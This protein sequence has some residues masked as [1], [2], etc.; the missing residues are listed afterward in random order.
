MPYL[1]RARLALAVEL[2]GCGPRL[3]KS[4]SHPV[5]GVPLVRVDAQAASAAAKSPSRWIARSDASASARE[6][7][8][9]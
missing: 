6:R 7:C 2:G 8:A 5:F 3:P 4:M 1:P 9:G